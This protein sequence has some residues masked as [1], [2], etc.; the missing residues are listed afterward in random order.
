MEGA[1]ED[2]RTGHEFVCASS[3]PLLLLIGSH[4]VRDLDPANDQYGQGLDM[5]H[6]RETSQSMG[7]RQ[8]RERSVE[9]AMTRQKSIP[10]GRGS[11]KLTPGAT[12]PESLTTRSQTARC[13][14]PGTA[15]DGMS[16]PRFIGKLITTSGFA[17]SRRMERWAGSSRVETPWF[18][19]GRSDVGPT[20]KVR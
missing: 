12:D 11:W 3:S 20:H 2:C 17:S 14:G 9:A 10:G 19:C 13:V 6:I 8:R 4:V 5:C 15:A 1:A 18:S 16:S 7:L